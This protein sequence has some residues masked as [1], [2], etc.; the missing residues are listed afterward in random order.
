M[1]FL[2]AEEAPSSHEAVKICSSSFCLINYQTLISSA[3]AVVITIIVVVAVV[4][5]R[6]QSLLHGKR[7][8]PVISN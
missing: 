5:W 1:M 2:A 8:R 6:V 4:A 7:R 3:I